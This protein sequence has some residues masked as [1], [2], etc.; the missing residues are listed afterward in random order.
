[1]VIPINWSGD[2]ADI[3]L[4]QVVALDLL[5]LIYTSHGAE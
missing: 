4:I 2:G 1:M 3:I 5:G